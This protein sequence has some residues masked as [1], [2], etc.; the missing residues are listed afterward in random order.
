MNHKALAISALTLVFAAASLA[1]G[2]KH[3][4]PAQSA[5]VVDPSYYSGLVWRNIG[6]FRGGRVSA[7]SGA[8]GHPG[9]FYAGMPGG[10]VWKTTNAGITWEPIFDSV[11]DASSV[12]AVQVAPSD[13]NIV[14]VGLGDGTT[15]GGHNEG[16]GV[17][18]STDAGKT[19]TH[20]GLDFA[21]Q[22]P[23][24]FVDPKDPNTLLVAV[25]GDSRTP[26]SD[27]GAYRSTDGGKTWTKTLIT[28]NATGVQNL[29][30]AFDQPNVILATTVRHLNFGVDDKLPSKGFKGTQIVKSTDGGIT[31]SQVKGTG[32]PASMAGRTCVAVA[33]HT[34]GKRMFFVSNAGLWR[35]DDGGDSWTQMDRDDYRVRNGQGGY[36]CG[37]YV[38]SRDPDTVYVLNTCSYVSHDGG[39][40]FTGFKGAPGGDDPQQMWIDP[41]DGNRLFFGVDQGPTISLDGGKTWSGWYNIANGQFYHIAVSNA[42][43]YWV[44]ATMQDSGAIGMSTRGNYG[45]IT[46]LDWSPNP[47]WEWGSITVDPLNPNTIYSTGQSN[48][49][50]K[51][52]FPTGQWV[53]VSP[54]NDPTQ[55]LVHDFNQPIMFSPTNP[56]ELFLGYQYLMSS[57]DGG[58]TWHKL[59]PDLSFPKGYVP[60]KPEE[61]KDEKKAPAVKKANEREPD[62]D[63]DDDDEDDAH[64]NPKDAM[65][66]EQE[67][68]YEGLQRRGGAGVISSL[69]PS[70][71]NG[72]IIWAGVSNGNIKLTRDHGENWDD[73]NI[74]DSK[75][76]IQCIDASHTDPA[77]AYVVVSSN[78]EPLV[79]RTKDYGQH[80]TKI[81]TGLP[82]GEATGSWA[83]VIRAD[84][85][86]DGLL[87]LG[88]ESSMYVSFDD[89]DHWQSLKLNSP[90]TSYRDMQVK[91][92]DLIVGT[93]GRSFW[94]L[95]DISPL[96]QVTAKLGNAYLFASG[97]AIRARRNVNQDTPMPPEVPHALNAPPGAIIYYYLGSKPSSDITLDVTDKDGNQIR[98]YSSAPIPAPDKPDLQPIPDF[99]KEVP[100]PMPAEVGCNRINWDLRYENPPSFSH[101]YD[102]SATPYLTPPTPWGPLVPP[103]VYSL[104][105]TVDGQKY[106]QKLTVKNDPRSP[107]S[108]Q[109]V[110]DQHKLQMDL[111]Q[112]DVQAMAGIKYV[113]E[114]KKEIADLQKS[115]LSKDVS[116]AI[117]GLNKKLDALGA[118]GNRG[119][120]FG[121]RNG[122]ASNP[123]LSSIQGEC[124]N[125]MNKMEF[126][127]IAPSQPVR[128]AVG[129]IVK[130]LEALNKSLKEVQ[131]KD[132]PALNTLLEKNGLAKLSAK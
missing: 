20:L 129:G 32:L 1:S 130:D 109:D 85:K 91:N 125:Y 15:G 113:E 107:G 23:S 78:A 93:Y 57:T 16:D 97:D 72:K 83:N 3:S 105:L 94:I 51:Q 84:T 95:D 65:E 26:N 64:I 71:V 27:R 10:G 121:F 22:I 90:N 116:D 35:S 123:T 114:L 52:S 70:S 31:W 126:G 37:V 36:N 117:D 108:A 56:H 118:S 28:D 29:A 63:G 4:N 77:S 61:K 66:R 40:T 62:V 9:V 112:G 33:M 44:Y 88:T 2:P 82:A 30:W 8:I 43:P 67:L 24:I 74:P 59:S 60:P 98:H 17:Y 124:I 104:T 50:I 101:G 14:Y 96:R 19:W 111:Y 21:K 12:G 131:G 42:W 120:G 55:H 47:G 92:D 76:A 49:V 41:T 38:N 79:Y 73:V 48:D 81:V 6:P 87:F 115:K 110:R 34:Q 80:W 100:R 128:E 5:G 122:G 103:G 106:T 99:W 46:P 127:D 25:L 119:R 86:K 39:K 53:S 18:K 132:V 69:S 102:I 7:A 45:E 89:G 75:K 13:P 58:K 11:K 54:D 68:M